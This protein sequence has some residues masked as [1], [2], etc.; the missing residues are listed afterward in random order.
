MKELKTWKENQKQQEKTTS[1]VQGNSH[2]TI[3]RFFL[4][5]CL[6]ARKEW[7]DVFK[8]LRERIPTQNTAVGKA[9]L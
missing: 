5:E 9:V 4:A 1:Y 7:H 2:K 6:Q 8:V 3:S